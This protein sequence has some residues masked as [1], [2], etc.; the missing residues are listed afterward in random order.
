[1]FGDREP[2]YIIAGLIFMIVLAALG[3]GV[4]LLQAALA[5]AVSYFFG[6]WIGS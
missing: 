6:T 2:V 4:F 1:M 3:M 5:T